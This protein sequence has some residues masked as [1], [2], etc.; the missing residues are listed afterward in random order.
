VMANN[1]KSA[2]HLY[3]DLWDSL[4]TEPGT[5]WEDNPWVVAVS[6]GVNHGNIDAGTA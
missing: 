6:F 4:H 5:R 2:N 1:R 3:A